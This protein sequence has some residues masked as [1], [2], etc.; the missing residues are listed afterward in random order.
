M[1]RRIFLKRTPCYGICPVYKLEIYPDGQ[2]NYF[3]EH[4]VRVEG[5]K[6]WQI[7]KK[8]VEELNYLIKKYDYFNLKEEMVTMMSTD[9]AGC[10]TEITMDDGRKRKIKN[11]YGCN[12]WPLKLKAFENRIDRI[13]NSAEYVEEENKYRR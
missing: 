6:S 11:D 10:I 5:F 12:Q 3:G 8:A 7:D 2:V 1:F 4:R 9:S 13:V